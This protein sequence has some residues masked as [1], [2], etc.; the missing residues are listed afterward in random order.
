M[1]APLV[2]ISAVGLTRRL[3][4]HAPRLNSLAQ[5]NWAVG[6]IE[7]SPAVTCTAQATLLTGKLPQN[8]GIVAN[9]WLFRDTREIR[10]WQQSHHLIQ[11]PTLPQILKA[12]KPSLKTANLFWWFNQGAPFDISVTPKPFYGANGDKRFGIDGFPRAVPNRL[13]KDLGPFPFPSF[14]GPRAGLPSTE[15]IAQAAANVLRNDKPDLLLAYLP[16]LDYQPQRVGVTGADMPAL[17]KQ[18]DD[19]AAPLLDAAKHAGARVWVVGEYGHCDVNQAV[20]LNRILRKAGLL[21]VR[22]GPFGEILDT[23]SSPAFA[24]AD[25]QI[26]H[27]YLNEQVYLNKKADLPKVRE[28]IASTPGVARVLAGDELNEIGLNHPRSGDLVALAQPHAWFS[29]PYWLDDSRAPD[30]ARTVDIHR[31][32]GYDPCELLVDPQLLWPTG[33]VIRRLMAKKM[34]FRT[35]F[36]IIPLN[37]ALVR[38]SHGLPASNPVDRPIWIG[39]GK[40]PS[41]DQ[42][43]TAFLQPLLTELGL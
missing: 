22:D 29:Y 9:G 6:Q 28:L 25:H 16:H 2:L 13:E 32:P 11:S 38:G 8:H 21:E 7:P 23:F 24:L 27:I 33:R 37:D 34:G 15:W 39:S 18:L 1:T 20:P 31:K 12:Q 36:D 43:M 41:T 17:V 26:A 42:P 40:A 30:F 19:A 4:P 14:W 5:A 35:L 3:L 10:L